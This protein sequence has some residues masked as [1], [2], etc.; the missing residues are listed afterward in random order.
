MKDNDTKRL[1]RLIAIL[2]QLQ[3]KRLLTASELSDKFSVSN[4]TIYRDIKA[5]GQAGVPILTEEGKGYKL[6]DGYRIPPVMLTESE[7]NALITAE[8]LILKNKEASL[9]QEYSAAIS[10]IKSVLRDNT[11]DKANLLSDRI[12]FRQNTVNERTSNYLSTLQLALTNFNLTKIKYHSTDSNQ[13]TERIIEPFAMYSTNENWLLVAFCRLR[14]DFRVFRLDQIQ[15]LHVF[16]DKFEPHKIT[17][18]EYFEICRAKY[19]SIPLT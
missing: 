7:A 8:Q 19:F 11:R 6:M 17:L 13:T 9:V 2:T 4:R 18:P 14:K 5:L 15:S 12:L 16:S 10:K 1:S 3:S